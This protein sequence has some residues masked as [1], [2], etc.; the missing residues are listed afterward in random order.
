M[1]WWLF[2]G[3]WAIGAVLIWG[4]VRG[5]TRKPTPTPAPAPTLPPIGRNASMR[6]MLGADAVYSDDA[7]LA[8]YC[9]IPRAT[10]VDIR[11][12][13]GK[14]SERAERRTGRESQIEMDR[15]NP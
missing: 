6:R 14:V 4:F 8:P 7:T 12:F 2:A 1:D 15:R 9:P 3:A 5:G 11:T 10:P 13:A